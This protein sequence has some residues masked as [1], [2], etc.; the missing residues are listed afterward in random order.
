MAI[1]QGEKRIID[2][3]DAWDRGVGHFAIC[4]SRKTPHQN[5]EFGYLKKPKNPHWRI[6]Q[7]YGCR[8]QFQVHFKSNNQYLA[9]QHVSGERR[10]I[11]SFFRIVDK[12]LGLRVGTKFGPTQRS[13]ISWIWVPKFWRES[14]VRRS[15]FTALLRAARKYVPTRKNFTEALYSVSYTRRTRLAV[16]R[17]FEGYTVFKNVYKFNMGWGWNTGWRDI[18]SIRTHSVPIYTQIDGRI[19]IDWSRGGY[20]HE[21][22]DIT[23]MLVKPSRRRKK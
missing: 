9:F 23:K 19:A 3:S 16:Q 10:R 8:E 2:D 4:Q 1:K 6:S 13:N 12:K 14:Y 18:F 20:R 11:A 5:R 21:P 7:Y 15:L 22:V 17:F